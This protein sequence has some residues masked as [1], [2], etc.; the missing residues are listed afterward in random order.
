VKPPLFPTILGISGPQ[1]ARCRVVSSCDPPPHLGGL[2]VLD[3]WHGLG[4]LGA[5][6]DLLVMVMM[7]DIIDEWFMI[8]I[9]LM[10]LIWLIW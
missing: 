10:W 8:L 4:V 6:A 1:L 7:N 9:W 5:V 2:V 3:R